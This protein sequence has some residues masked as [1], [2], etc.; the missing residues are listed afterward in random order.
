MK[1]GWEVKTLGE[2]CFIARGGSPRP[3]QEF[4]TNDADGVNWIKISDATA[5]DRY[6][7]ETKQ[8]IKPSGIARSRL[9]NEGDF[10][11]SNSMSFGR[12]YIMKTTGCIHD[13][14]LVLSKYDQCFDQGFLYHLLNS[15]V[16]FEQFDKLAAGSTVRNL[17]IELASRV[18]LPVP[19]LPEQQRI[20]AILDEAFESIATAKANAQ[21]NLKNAR[22]LFESH[23]NEVFT[24]RG[25]GW[26]EKTLGDICDF[27]QG[28]QVDVKLQSETKITDNQV[29]FL[30]IV[31]FTQGNEP[32]RYINN[33]DDKFLV[34]SSDISLVRYGASTG[35][36]CRGLEGA[37]ANNLFRVI[38]KK[39]YVSNEFL[40]W[41]LNAPLFQENI[42]SR[43]NGAAMPAISF[44]MI[45]DIPFPFPPSNDQQRLVATFDILYKETQH[46]E[47]LY[48]HKITALDELKKSLLHRA[49]AGEL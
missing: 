16:V 27:S 2:S 23:L 30:R 36:V 28:I 10:L 34:T 40:Y 33:L 49:F 29:R 42:K 20:V 18:V 4:L 25:E 43:M 22:A 5:S 3:I 37:I 48:Q 45:N 13:G 17:N 9:V 1:A 6:I 39:N 24:K 35:F 38:P 41:F 32:A 46:L 44:S 11:L 26:E 14:W 8:K 31:D 47:S 12:P 21:Q 19:P 7:F 15:P